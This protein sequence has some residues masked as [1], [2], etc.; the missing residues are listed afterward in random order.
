MARAY[1]ALGSNL[2]GRLE[3]LRQALQHLAPALKI[4]RVSPVY[5]TG[6]V[7]YLDQPRFLNA[8]AEGETELEP[9]DL[10]R[11][12]QAVEERLGRERSFPNAPR[13][14]DL[15]LLFYDDRVLDHAD[16]TLPHPRL[17]E[18][19]FV[20]V[21]LADIAPDLLHPRL[22]RTVRELLCDLAAE[23]DGERVD[24]EL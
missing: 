7:G 22:G 5:E 13:T 6:P 9:L 18:R 1:I 17:H 16:L 2:G 11:A 20:L 3:N 23:W 24:A 4:T 10:L 21:P 19:H 14:I 12:M 8:V 15:D